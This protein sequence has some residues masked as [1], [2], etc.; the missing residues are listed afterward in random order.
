MITEN[1]LTS[2]NT[3]FYSSANAGYAVY[4][5]TSLM[6]IRDHLPDAKL[7]MLSSGLSDH[8]RRL[9]ENNNIQYIEQDLSH[10]FTQTWEYPI[11]CYYLF[12]GPEIF[13]GLGYDF[14]VYVDGDILCMGDPLLEVKNVSTVAGVESRGYDGKYTSIFGDDWARICNEWSLP[15][16]RAKRKRINAGVVY[17]NNHDMKN[18]NFLN[19]AAELFRVS[20]E[21]GI[22]RKGDDSLFSLYQYVYLDES[23]I[24]ILP[25][26]FN[27]VI[28][29]NDG[30]PKEDPVFFHFSV[31]KPWK[32]KPYA[33]DNKEL[34][35]F[36]SYVKAWRLKFRKVTFIDWLKSNRG[37]KVIFVFLM[38]FERYFHKLK[39]VVWDHYLWIQ[40]LKTSLYTRRMN[41]RK[42]ALK[43]Y[44]WRDFD[45]NTQNFGDEIT[46]DIIQRI[47]GYQ[48]DLV[49]P[50]DAE[51]I[52]VGSILEVAQE[53]RSN[54][55]LHVWGSGFILPTTSETNDVFLN[56]IFHAVRGRD[57]RERI[58]KYSNGIVQVGDP[59]L[60]VNLVY[61]RA[62]FKT[63]KVGVVAHYADSD[64]PVM[65]IL[66]K[67]DRFL[68]IDPLSPPDEVA[69]MITSCKLILSS[70]LHGLI[71]ADSYGIPNAHLKLSDRLKGGLYK[72]NDYCSAVGKEYK[73]ADINQVL[74]DKYL[75]GLVRDY[76]P[77]V[78]IKATQRSLIK[79]FPKLR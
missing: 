11:D 49:S 36:N 44:W 79:S 74:D 54:K 72:F 33:H 70:S 25:P 66:K 48:C 67:D 5:A 64:L 30:A 51:L 56:T 78:N 40:G 31:D 37:F 52:G 57:S 42:M 9:L 17:F 39:R 21:K 62:G 41:S 50:D 61:E 55:K 45:K 24:L 1:K 14:S 58:K 28:Q 26:K 22:P 27:Y 34:N 18:R 4:A 16:D 53:K 12:S 73:S 29:F 8:E 75:R 13:L 63:N 32:I 7:F 65:D 19:A 46:K 59:G 43:V 69:R 20:L 3:V 68:V 76:D 71:F 6:T 60:L 38:K 10:L 35:I 2:D 23:D 77:I 47:F 15:K